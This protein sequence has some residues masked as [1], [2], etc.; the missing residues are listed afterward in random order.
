MGDSS[1]ITASRENYYVNLGLVGF[2]RVIKAHELM[3]GLR[4]R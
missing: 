1:I 3:D 2:P 4:S